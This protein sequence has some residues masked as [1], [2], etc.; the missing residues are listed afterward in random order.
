MDI[1][2]QIYV[3]LSLPLASVQAVYCTD[4][5]QCRSLGSMKQYSANWAVHWVEMLFIRN[6]LGHFC[7]IFISEYKWDQDWSMCIQLRLQ[8]VT[9]MKYYCE[10]V[11]AVK[12][13]SGRVLFCGKTMNVTNIRKHYKH[14]HTHTRFLSSNKSSADPSKVFLLGKA[15]LWFCLFVYFP[16][17]IAVTLT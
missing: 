16:S 13:R 4:T 11:I 8:L 17:L 1:W 7:H 3:C 10:S 5:V 2:L 9:C 15:I 6:C 12:V 14:T